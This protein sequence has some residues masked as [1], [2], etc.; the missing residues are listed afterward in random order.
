V[1]ATERPAIQRIPNFRRFSY[2]WL[3]LVDDDTIISVSKVLDVIG[4]YDDDTGDVA[5][6]ELYGKDTSPV[7][8]DDG[9][10]YLSGG[11]GKLMN[12][13]SVEKLVSMLSNFY[14]LSARQRGRTSYS[15]CTRKAYL[16]KSNT[17]EL[18]P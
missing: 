4:C 8:Q 14:S 7:P 13:R 15:V 6:G 2:D 9:F 16:A 18:G 5:V 17:I 12:R 3:V 1:Q 11:A 10:D